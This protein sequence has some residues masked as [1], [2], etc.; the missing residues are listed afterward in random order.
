M[1]GEDRQAVLICAN[2]GTTHYVFSGDICICDVKWKSFCFG[3][4]D[5][6]DCYECD[7]LFCWRVFVW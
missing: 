6:F 1:D 5:W 3:R 2:C 7:C 4:K